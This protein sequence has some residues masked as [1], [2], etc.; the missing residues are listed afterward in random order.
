MLD[1][2][3]ITINRKPHDCEWD[4]APIGNKHCRYDEVVTVFNSDDKVID[5]TGIEVNASGTEISYDGK[6]TWQA[7]PFDQKPAKVRVAWDRAED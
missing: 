4:S 3:Q 5:G 2:D 1:P 6:K 7:R